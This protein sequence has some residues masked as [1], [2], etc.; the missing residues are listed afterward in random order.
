M[1][2]QHFK[3]D[4]LTFFLNYKRKEINNA[5]IKNTLTF[6]LRILRI[7]SISTITLIFST[8]FIYKENTLNI[9]LPFNIVLLAFLVIIIIVANKYSWLIYIY[10]LI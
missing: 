7:I 8:F 1:L 4:K 5:F 2:I 10:A 9:V 3:D 6:R